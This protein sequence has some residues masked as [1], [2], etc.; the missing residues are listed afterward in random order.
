[1]MTWLLLWQGMEPCNRYHHIRFFLNYLF[2]VPSFYILYQ[3]CFFYIVY[4]YILYH[5]LWRRPRD[6]H[7]RFNKISDTT[8]SSV[9]VSLFFYLI[10]PMPLQQDSSD[11]RV[12]FRFFLY[13]KQVKWYDNKLQWKQCDLHCC[14]VPFQSTR[15]H[16]VQCK[17]NLYQHLSF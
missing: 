3:I 2:N 17:F 5:K 15:C 6:R 8:K 13:Y 11:A 10:V 4:F 7:V 14:R 1:M 9:R 16:S 12:P